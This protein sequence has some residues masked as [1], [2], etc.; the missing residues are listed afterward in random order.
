MSNANEQQTNGRRARTERREKKFLP[1]MSKERRDMTIL[2]E[3][4]IMEI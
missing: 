3:A 2:R 4:G 1:Y